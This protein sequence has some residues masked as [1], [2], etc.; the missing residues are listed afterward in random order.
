MK[1]LTFVM[2]VIFLASLAFA[3]TSRPETLTA[4]SL[5]R[6]VF[7][8]QASSV[9]ESG[10]TLR[11]VQY[12]TREGRITDLYLNGSNE[13]RVFAI[14]SNI[15][16]QVLVSGTF[17]GQIRLGETIFSSKG[18]TDLFYL[19]LDAEGVLVAFNSFG[20]G[21]QDYLKKAR[22]DLNG[23]FIL[24]W[25]SRLSQEIDHELVLVGFGG[26]MHIL[27][28]E[29]MDED[30]GPDLGLESEEMDEDSGP[31]L[32]LANEEMDEDSG[33]DLGLANEEM[34]EDSGPDLALSSYQP[35]TGEV[36]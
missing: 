26:T 25:V 21:S 31:D 9:S 19:V 22:T 15:H 30:S 35:E 12:F 34:D 13:L 33:P 28:N 5:D 7:V 18:S 16:D 8:E 3:G 29:E 4:D 36:F 32:G 2:N 14:T 24:T 23:E 10:T 11:L 17:Q 27:S 6:Q 1:A 20:S